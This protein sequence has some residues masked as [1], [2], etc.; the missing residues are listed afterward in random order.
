[1]KP[2]KKD[3]VL[4]SG[5]KN[6]KGNS[7][8]IPQ[9][10]SAQ[11]IKVIAEKAKADSSGLLGA[12][13]LIVLFCIIAFIAAHA[14]G[15]G[16]VIWVFIS[17]IF[18]NNQRAAGQSLGSFTHWIFAALLTMVFPIVIK[19]FDAG[20]IFAFFCLM[21]VF[22]LVWVKLMVPETKGKTLEELEK[23]VVN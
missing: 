13:S 17:E 20:F 16:A 3:L 23:E 10:I 8:V 11:Q 5:L 7:I 21:M 6:Y 18:P 2:Q 15:Q 1:M 4:S 14:V 12:S 22:Q 9:N 19:K